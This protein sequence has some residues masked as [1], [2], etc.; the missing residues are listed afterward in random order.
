M[1]QY[2]N[3]P[4]EGITVESCLVG[5]WRKEIGD[6]VAAGD[7]LFEYETDKAAF[8]CVS[9][10]AGTLLY[11]FY[12]AGDEAPVLKPVAV[13]GGVGEDVS[14]FISG[15]GG[16][17]G[18]QGTQAPGTATET[19][20]TEHYDTE[21]AGEES[22]AAAVDTG[23]VDTG[24]VY[25]GDVDTG[26][27]YA[28]TMT[29][30]GNMAGGAPQMIVSPRARSLAEARDVDLSCVTPTG[31]DGRILEA[32]V[33][34]AANK[35]Y[36]ALPEAIKPV[37]QEA[38]AEAI[39][40]VP[41]KAT[42]ES[43]P[44][45]A[46]N[47]DAAQVDALPEAIMPVPPEAAPEAVAPV[48]QEAAAP[49]A[50]EAITSVPPEVAAP[51]A[52][53]PVTPEPAMESH[54]EAAVYVD[55]AQVDA[56]PEAAAPVPPEAITPVTPEPAAEDHAYFDEQ[57]SRIRAVIAKTMTASLQ[58]GAQV[59]HH[60]SFDATSILAMRE[61]FKTDGDAIAYRDVSIGDIILYV[62]SRVLSKHPEINALVAETGVR[63]Y[64]TVNLGVAVDTPRGLMVPTVFSAEKKSLLEISGEVKELAAAA[65][66][67]RI[68]PDRLTDGTFT[69]SNLGA[70]GV[71]S[72][73]P[74]INPP[75]AAIAGITGIVDRVRKGKNGRVE[76]YPSIGISLTYD[77]RAIDGAPASRFAAELC[78]ALTDFSWKTLALEFEHE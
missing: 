58:R 17:V 74:I 61:D 56:L 44:E 13:I 57:F 30:T 37:Q 25:T 29:E 8:E 22:F 53:T 38:A 55:A 63:K 32:D 76:V 4:K 42:V 6:A 31:P 10:A 27:I 12:Q 11:K 59:T 70:T 68:S 34:A 69:V 9:T 24:A 23:A 41:L 21:T 18:A 28:G 5:A 47:A 50:P 20:R 46:V 15:G 43:H 75:Q 33:I 51:E 65:K 35:A 14:A 26:A 19:V 36:D 60:H 52:I 77:H 62:T 78:S 40:P 7:V 48:Q 66:E 64:F 72:F 67:G 54:P 39:T 16:V 49:V 71:E 3:M 45:A 73:T 1:A 2:V